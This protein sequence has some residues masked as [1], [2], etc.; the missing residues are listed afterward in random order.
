[1]ANIISTNPGDN[2]VA[3]EN[4]IDLRG[5]LTPATKAEYRKTAGVI[6]GFDGVAQG[7]ALNG[8]QQGI[9]VNH[10]GPKDITTVASL[11]RLRADYG[12]LD[13]QMAIDVAKQFAITFMKGKY[14]EYW[15]GSW[16]S[17]FGT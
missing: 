10:K 14:T 5:D 4:R 13:G 3:I 16:C 9:G 11:E 7:G 8:G 6:L 17:C 1:M 15:H 12:I 2:L